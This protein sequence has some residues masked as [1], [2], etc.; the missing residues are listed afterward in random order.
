[1][2]STL[3]GDVVEVRK[4]FIVTN[5][6]DVRFSVSPVLIVF[7]AVK[8]AENRKFPALVASHAEICETTSPFVPAQLAQLG[9]FDM[10]LD[11][12]DAADHDTVG[13]VVTD[14]AFAVPAEPGSPVCN[15][16]AHVLGAVKAVPANMSSHLFAKLAALIPTVMDQ[17]SCSASTALITSASAVILSPQT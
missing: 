14:D 5:V 9:V 10:A 4:Q 16:T 15:F 8:V 17:P 6:K 13:L 3:M 1:V 2:V 11:P 12:A 7:E